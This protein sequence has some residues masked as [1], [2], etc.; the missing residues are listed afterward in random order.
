MLGES[1]ECIPTLGRIGL[2][3]TKVQQGLTLP[4]KLFALVDQEVGAWSATTKV[5][6]CGI[7]QG[8]LGQG[9]A[10]LVGKA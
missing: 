4:P 10:S 9:L 2:G 5:G 1:I 7:Q 3:R 8:L 6:R